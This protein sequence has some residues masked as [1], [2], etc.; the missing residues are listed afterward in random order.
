MQKGASC[1][2]TPSCRPSLPS[3]LPTSNA[4]RQEGEEGFAD[5][6]RSL[7]PQAARPARGENFGLAACRPPHYPPIPPFWDKIQSTPPLWHERTI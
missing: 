4:S 5:P 2:A 3:G 1:L 6:Q 7:K